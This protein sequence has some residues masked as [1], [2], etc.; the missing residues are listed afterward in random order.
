MTTTITASQFLEAAK[1]EHCH[2]V[3]HHAL[4]LSAADQREASIVELAQLRSEVA[5]IRRHARQDES[6]WA[7]HIAE[8]TAENTELKAALDKAENKLM[9]RPVRPNHRAVSAPCASRPM[10]TRRCER[11]RN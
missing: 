3:V 10:N 2:S 5:A 7:K 4:L 8:L 1:Q 9:A 11:R 6:V